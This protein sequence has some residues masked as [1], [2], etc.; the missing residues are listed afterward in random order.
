MRRTG[1]EEHVMSQQKKE[2]SLQVCVVESLRWLFYNLQFY[3]TNLVSAPSL[4]LLISAL[5]FW[6]NQ[7]KGDICKYTSL[8]GSTTSGLW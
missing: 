6:K 7:G 5:V 1:G 4:E 3:C 8:N 2:A